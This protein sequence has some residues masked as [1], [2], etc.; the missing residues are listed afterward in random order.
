[1]A[2]AETAAGLLG[3]G[4][5]AAHAHLVAA[6]LRIFQSDRATLG[7]TR[8]A[9]TAL[10]RQPATRVSA[11]CDSS[12][13][14]RLKIGDDAAHI[15]SNRDWPSCDGV[16]HTP[17]VCETPVPTGHLSQDGNVRLRSQGVGQGRGP[18]P[19]RHRSNG[20][21]QLSKRRTR[22]W[23][24]TQPITNG[25][26][27]SPRRVREDSVESGLEFVLDHAL[28]TKAG[29]LIGLRRLLEARKAVSELERRG[30]AS[31]FIE[32][33]TALKKAQL[34][35]AA[36]D[37]KRAEVEL[38][39][40]PPSA[41]PLGMYEEWGGTAADS[42]R[43]CRVCR[44]GDSNPQGKLRG[45]R[46]CR[47]QKPR[48]ARPPDHRNPGPARRVNRYPASPRSWP[49]AIG[50]LWS[51]LVALSPLAAELATRP[52]LVQPLQSLLNQLA[53]RRHRATSRT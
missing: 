49:M 43:G 33:Q 4:E 31:D 25:R 20:S 27:A 10:S 39:G 53:R 45:A 14:K 11:L 6:G 34:R 37:L 42:S 15:V 17:C 30:A 32:R 18:A 19:A 1:M 51:S 5:L 38:S 16:Q 52:G 41:A 28:I 8:V 46:P 23:R 35:V 44:L 47:W 40:P 22:S 21:H 36:G 50:I 3:N 7:G 29:A 48:P 26:Y 13:F 2:L 12:C 24:S 9:C